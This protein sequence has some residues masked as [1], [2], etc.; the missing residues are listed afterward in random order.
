MAY[1]RSASANF[2]EPL[3][4]EPEQIRWLTYIA[5]SAGYRGLGV[6]SDRFLADSHQG[7]DRL[8][9]LALLNQEMLLLE[10]LLINAKE[11]LWRNTSNPEVTAAIFHTYRGVLVLPI[12]LRHAPQ[13]VLGQSTTL[14]LT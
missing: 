11:P 2:V 14:K 12:W 6:W 13:F 7:R 5:L 3:A 10:P 9:T 1:P 8:L 4:P